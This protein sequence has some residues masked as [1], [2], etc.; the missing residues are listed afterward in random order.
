MFAAE[1]CRLSEPDDWT[2]QSNQQKIRYT[3]NDKEY[4]TTINRWKQAKHRP[5]L[6][7]KNEIEPSE[8]ASAF[9][10]CGCEIVEPKHTKKKYDYNVWFRYRGVL[11]AQPKYRILMLG[12]KTYLDKRER[13][14]YD[15]EFRKY[16]TD[17]NIEYIPEWS[18]E[19]LKDK[20]KLRYDFYLPT[21][22]LLIELD[23]TKHISSERV[24]QRDGMKEAY[25]RE[26]Q[27]KLLR[28]SNE[29]RDYE[30][31]FN[32]AQSSEEFIVKVGELYK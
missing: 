4:S 18:F 17:H 8:F 22:K 20:A 1:D 15:Y 10:S 24:K 23:D 7:R 9:K 25:A 30:T 26:H 32:M 6:S 21:L 28:I 2:Y 19:D 13:A 11:Y 5:H 12:I 16:C 31:A 29:H 14:V 27:I 3:Y